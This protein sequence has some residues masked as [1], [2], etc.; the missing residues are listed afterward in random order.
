MGRSIDAT[1]LT[2]MHT[3]GTCMCVC[4]RW[5]EIHGGGRR[6]Y[7]ESLPSEDG[8]RT[9]SSGPHAAC[10][11]SKPRNRL[12]TPNTLSPPQNTH[13]G[14][15][16]GRPP[17]GRRPPRR[18]GCAHN[19]TR[20]LDLEREGERYWIQWE[21][22]GAGKAYAC[23]SIPSHLTTHPRTTPTLLLHTQNRTR[24]TTRTRRTSTPSG[25]RVWRRAC[26]WSTRSRFVESL[27][28]IV[29]DGVV[30]FLGACVVVWGGES[31]GLCV[32]WGWGW[33]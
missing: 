25:S 26:P 16:H 21:R 32:L 30:F 5:D 20:R 33:G 8:G 10:I 15:P 14:A 3:C 18:G 1:A 17:H 6:L 2:Y 28:L 22:I 7:A 23:T 12:T 27:D 24:R 31:G 19:A 9:F 29:E 11:T 13:S 4:V